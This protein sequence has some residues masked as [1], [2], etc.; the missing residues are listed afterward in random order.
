MLARAVG[1][2]VMVSLPSSLTVSL[3]SRL[4]EQAGPPTQSPPCGG[5]WGVGGG[6]VGY[7]WLWE[8]VIVAACGLPGSGPSRMGERGLWVTACFCRRR[9]FLDCCAGFIEICVGGCLGLGCFCE[10]CCRARVGVA[11]SVFL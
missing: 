6:S 9:C 8:L 10:S 3:L 5:V 11:L 1:F 4:G 2:V 7:L